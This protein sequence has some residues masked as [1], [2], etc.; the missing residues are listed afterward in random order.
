MLS[1]G[2]WLLVLIGMMTMVGVPWLM[3]ESRR[4]HGADA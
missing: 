2:G 1:L 4:T 3:R